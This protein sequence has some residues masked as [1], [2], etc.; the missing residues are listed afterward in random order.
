MDSLVVWTTEN[1][2][3][4]GAIPVEEYT[5]KLRTQAYEGVQYSYNCY[6]WLR[7]SKDEYFLARQNALDRAS[8]EAED[9]EAKQLAL[10]AKEKLGQL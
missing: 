7:L 9:E 5:E 8:R 10:E 6:V 1:L 3:V 2:D 4:S